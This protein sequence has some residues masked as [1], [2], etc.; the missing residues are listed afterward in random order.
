MF[1]Q[2]LD[3]CHNSLHFLMNFF[4]GIIARSIEGTCAIHGYGMRKA[5]CSFIEPNCVNSWIPT[6]LLL[7]L[8]RTLDLA[9]NRFW[10][11]AAWFQMFA[12]RS[13]M[14]NFMWVSGKK[15]FE[16]NCLKPDSLFISQTEYFVVSSKM[17]LSC[18]FHNVEFH[19]VFGSKGKCEI[20]M[21]KLLTTYPC[22]IIV[23]NK[24]TTLHSV[25]WNFKLTYFF[26]SND[27]NRV[28]NR[29]LIYA[30]C[31]GKGSNWDLFPNQY[32]FQDVCM[33]YPFA[34]WLPLYWIEIYSRRRNHHPL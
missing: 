22:R 16:I 20:T 4:N 31:Q 19:Y 5:P 18:T 28:E 24:S 15:L 9:S 27:Q 7:N 21:G 2:L 34:H 13:W 6:E 23:S 26:P 1:Y 10:I 25:L 3:F 14:T 33:I 30:P 8:I 17:W 12:F 11:I 32:L 29:P